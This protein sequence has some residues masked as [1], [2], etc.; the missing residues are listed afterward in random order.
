MKNF[1][2]L[3]KEM[4]EAA[5]TL[6]DYTAM[7]LDV[8]INRTKYDNTPSGID[9]R[10][11]EKTLVEQ[12]AC[13]LFANDGKGPYTMERFKYLC[14]PLAGGF[15]LDF[16]GDLYHRQAAGCG[17]TYTGLTPENSVIIYN[18]RLRCGNISMLRWYAA[19]M[20][21][22]TK[23]ADAN[24]EM[25]RFSVIVK[26]REKTRLSFLNAVK[27]F[28]NGLPFIFSTQENGISQKDFETLNFNIPYI[29]DKCFAYNKELW[30]ECLTRLGIDALNINKKERLLTGE[31]ESEKSCIEI[32][33][34]SYL[35]E[36][37]TALNKFNEI[38][39][40]DWRVEWYDG[41]IYNDN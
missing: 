5:F 21:E 3:K 26:S 17:H 22:A 10:F 12:G 7:L 4:C 33:R 20:Y 23:N 14:L 38:F 15:D 24:I 8:A 29:A 11:M 36:R 32:Y 35:N 31:V 13:V 6:G 27:K 28:Q 18:N 40:T 39:G 9:I 30:T 41:N 25:Q 16:Y 37:Q 1:D 34:Q 2:P 19:R